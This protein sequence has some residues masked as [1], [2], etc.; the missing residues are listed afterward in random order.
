MGVFEG[1][2]SVIVGNVGGD[3]LNV[4]EDVDGVE[5]MERTDLRAKNADAIV[6]ALF[7]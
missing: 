5:F 4:P 7:S 1:V 2:V 3:D 6:V